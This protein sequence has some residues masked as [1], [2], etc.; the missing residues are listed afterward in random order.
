MGGKGRVEDV[1]VVN[2]EEGV[3]VGMKGKVWEVA[4]EGWRTLPLR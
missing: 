2:G 4:R 3:G 1:G